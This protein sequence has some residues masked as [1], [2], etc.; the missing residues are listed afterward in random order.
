M[1]ALAIAYF[2]SRVKTAEREGYPLHVDKVRQTNG[3]P[4]SVSEK[5]MDAAIE[6][7]LIYQDEKGFLRVK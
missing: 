2:I 1:N 4:S 5:A 3:K 7:G 6:R